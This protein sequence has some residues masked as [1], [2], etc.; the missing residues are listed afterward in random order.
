MQAKTLEGMA[1]SPAI[2]L[3]VLKQGD[4]RHG[5]ISWNIRR[6]GKDLFSDPIFIVKEGLNNSVDE[7]ARFI[8]IGY[9]G[10]V[11][12]L[13]RRVMGDEHERRR[14]HA[15]AAGEPHGHELAVRLSLLRALKETTKPPRR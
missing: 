14:L 7:D 9:D 11:L 3:S 10:H 4:E 2:Q 6:V 13:A 1:E 8:E 5:T 15:L 12:L